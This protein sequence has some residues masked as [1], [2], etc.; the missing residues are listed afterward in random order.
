MQNKLLKY[1]NDGL[2]EQ[3]TFY[4]SQ[5]LP[6]QI[7]NAIY[8]F[9]DNT[10]LDI[11]GF[12]DTSLLQDGTS[13]MI[14]TSHKI[15]YVLEGK[16]SF[17]YQDICSLSLKKHR[18]QQAIAKIQTHQKTYSFQSSFLNEELWL[19][20]LSDITDINIE[21]VL[22]DHEKIEYYTHIILNDIKN[23]EYEDVE[24]TSKQIKQIEEFYQELDIINTLDDENYKYELEKLCPRILQFIDEL[25]LDSDEIDMIED[26]QNKL[27]PPV[28][29][30]F[31]QAKQYYEDMMNKYKQ[32]DTQMFD[33]MQQTMD[34]L[35]IHPQD[36]Q[37]KS[38]DELN[39][40][41]D[42]LCDRFHIS[43]SQLDALTKKF[44]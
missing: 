4:T 43:R 35:G 9:G 38:P 27:T 34:T 36:F 13:G 11:L 20:F 7:G 21:I 41:I 24:L 25:E 17:S 39:A 42:E 2:I 8:E 33:Q 16:H 19:Q 5:T 1:I 18:H 29:H 12:I 40:Y 37:G 31:T 6:A 44:R 22:T 23:D 28:D 32:G 14:I 15:Y 3:G 10:I 30:T 26:I